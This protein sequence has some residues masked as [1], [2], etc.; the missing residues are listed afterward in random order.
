V[1]VGD[2]AFQMTGME[3]STIVRFGLNPIIVVLNNGGYGT[4]RPMMDGPFNDILSWRYARI[5]EFFGKG[6]KG[7][8]VR[9]EEDL[10]ASLRTGWD[11]KEGFS[12]LD[13]Q[14]DPSDASPALKRLTAALAK[15]VK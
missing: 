14:L 15:K 3:L 9:T 5:P 1:I 13:V 7:F 10:N 8:E 4:E 11:H 2:G 6:G 12:I